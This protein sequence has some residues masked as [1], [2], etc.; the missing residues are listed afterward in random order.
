MKQS[1]PD[2]ALFGG[3]DNLCIQRYQ[4]WIIKLVVNDTIVDWRLLT[5]SR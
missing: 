1:V 5:G 2:D 4:F 3:S